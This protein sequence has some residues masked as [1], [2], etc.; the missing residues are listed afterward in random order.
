MACLRRVSL[1]NGEWEKLL[2][3]WEK[4]CSEYG[5]ALDDF[6]SASIPMMATV[7]SG[8]QLSDRAI[9]ALENESGYQSVCQLNVAFLPGYEGKVLRVRTLVLAPRFDFDEGIDLSVYG[10]VL[11]ATFGGVVD[12]AREQMPARHIKFHFRSPADRQFFE[13]LR[14]ELEPEGQFAS[15]AMKGA[16]LYISMRS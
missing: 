2:L 6:A 7:A 4:E 1:Q 13:S 11:G 3:Q 12:V 16:W 9:Y 5:E 10:D 15:V 14:T 8:P